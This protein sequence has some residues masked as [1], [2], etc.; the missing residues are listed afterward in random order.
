MN[1]P[2]KMRPEKAAAEAILRQLRNSDYDYSK[3]NI[4]ARKLM[5]VPSRKFI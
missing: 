3:P 5:G 2:R 4:L 1:K